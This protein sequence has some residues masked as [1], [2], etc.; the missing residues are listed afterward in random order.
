MWNGSKAAECWWD[1]GNARRFL[2][3]QA[4]TGLRVLNS[5][6]KVGGKCHFSF[7]KKYIQLLC[8][9]G[10]MPGTGSQW[11]M[12]TVPPLSPLNGAL[13]P[14]WLLCAFSLYNLLTSCTYHFVSPSSLVKVKVKSL[15]CVRLFAT[16]WTV[17][18]QVPPSMGFSR[19][20]YWS[21]LP[22]PSP[23]KLPDPGIEP[24]SPALQ[25]NALLSEPPA[26]LERNSICLLHL[27]IW[28]LE[29]CLLA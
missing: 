9:E 11:R 8:M 10:T 1:W 2:S 19:Q 7:T 23:G 18:Y 27:F 13:T 4:R 17:A 5:R 29:P 6:R 12:N 28:R 21:G 25:A 15:S 14:S 16:P 22:F 26:S 20:E 3:L 24:G